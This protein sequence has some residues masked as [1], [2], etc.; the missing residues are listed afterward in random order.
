MQWPI[1]SG[2]PFGLVDGSQC[3]SA[4]Q[5]RRED[6][7]ARQDQQMGNVFPSDRANIAASSVDDSIAALIG[8]LP[9]PVQRLDLP[10]IVKEL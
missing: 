3:I 7:R 6:S 1:Q 2:W 9:S 8:L 5:M 4:C 10:G